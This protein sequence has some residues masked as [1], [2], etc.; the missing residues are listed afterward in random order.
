MDL[1]TANL[2]LI[3]KQA[4]LDWK[5]GFF[6][7]G[8]LIHPQIASTIP[9]GTRQTVFAMLDVLPQ[10]RE[11][12]GNRKINNAVA[13][14][15]VITAAPFEGTCRLSKWDVLDDQLGLFGLAVRALGETAAIWP[16]ELIAAA[17][18]AMSVTIGYDGVP[19]YS[20]AHPTNNGV[21]GPAAPGAPATQS[22]LYL[23]TPLTYDNYVTVYSNMKSLVYSN[24]A[25]MAL[26][27][28]ILMVPPQLERQGRDILQSQWR[29][30]LAGD[31]SNFAG[32]GGTNTY[33]NSSKLVV[34]PYLSNMPNNWWLL[35][36]KASVKAYAFHQRQAPV[37]TYL[38]SPS[39]PNVFLAAE[40][41]YGV[42]MRGAASETLWFLSAAGTAESDYIPA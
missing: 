5:E 22:N 15:R 13:L 33:M 20:T 30:Q 9:M 3:F 41:L 35:S 32:I 4:S 25:P 31:V 23:S 12:I 29:Q 7:S 24:G 6:G 42:D 36:Q 8:D 40:F 27:P 14:D 11:W 19:V 37:F 26:Q 1:S 39:D 17:V 2:E 28:Q 21:A 18:A 16:D 34:N 38:T 10:V